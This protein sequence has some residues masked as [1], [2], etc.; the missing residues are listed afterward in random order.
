MSIASRS[1]RAVTRL[2][3]SIESIS[4]SSRSSAFGST[5]LASV[6]GA[7]RPS[8]SIRMALMS[9]RVIALRALQSAV[10][11]GEEESTAMAVA[12]AVVGGEGC[13][14]HMPSGYLPGDDPWPFDRH[15][16]ADERDLR[17]VDDAE[18][19]F[20]A[21]LAEIGD[22]DR[23]I[24]QLGAAQRPAASAGD[25]VAQPRHQLVERKFVRVAN[26]RCDEA[27]AADRDRRTDMDAGPEL[28]PF[29]GKEPVELRRLAE[30]TRNA[31]EQQ[32]REQQPLRR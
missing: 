19:R 5:R 2:R 9:S 6:S 31:L 14:Q 10:D 16:K 23:R 18:H 22:R 8:S 12:R 28:K 1:V 4:S 24:R 32:C 20:D 26:S 30:R 7:I 11:I 27:T 17:R 29:G 3:K 21:A 13:R 15:A 25:E